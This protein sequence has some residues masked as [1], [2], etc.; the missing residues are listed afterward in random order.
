MDCAYRLLSL[1]ILFSCLS[2]L[3][4]D[5]LD[6]VEINT[7][8]CNVLHISILT[9]S[10]CFLVLIL[11][12]K[13]DQKRAPATLRKCPRKEN[14]PGFNQQGSGDG[15]SCLVA[16][17]LLPQGPNRGNAPTPLLATDKP[18]RLKGAPF[19]FIY[20]SHGVGLQ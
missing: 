1:E 10:Q 18:M 9:T 11:K 15:D 3:H 2:V 16:T 8:S 13:S 17:Q 6:L 14:H 4:R 12:I 19:I 20:T 7:Y 5:K